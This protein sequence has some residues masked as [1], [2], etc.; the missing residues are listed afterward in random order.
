MH[1]YRLCLRDRVVCLRQ[2]SNSLFYRSYFPGHPLS[3]S[4]QEIKEA[5]TL[6]WLSDYFQLDVD[7]VKLYDYWSSKDPVFKR[8]K[9]RFTGIRV[10]RQDPWENLV[11]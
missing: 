8:V 3:L 7:L 11:S 10:L 5:E 1:E 6:K 4:E 2:S 9:S